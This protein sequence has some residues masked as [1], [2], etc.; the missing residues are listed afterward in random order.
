MYAYL[1]ALPGFSFLLIPLV[2]VAAGLGLI[3]LVSLVWAIYRGGPKPITRFGRWAVI[4]AAVI[5]VGLAG[6]N[7]LFLRLG[8]EIS[9]SALESAAG[10]SDSTGFAGIYPV[11]YVSPTQHGSTV[12]VGWPAGLIDDVGFHRSTLGGDGG[13]CEEGGFALALDSHWYAVSCGW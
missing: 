4:A 5:A 9:R 10:T 11:S 7:D 1:T 6:W 3:W 13:A 2:N 12:W 8:F